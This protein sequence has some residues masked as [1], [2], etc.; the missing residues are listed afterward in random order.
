M[1]MH[2]IENSYLFKG[3]DRELLLPILSRCPAEQVE[4]GQILIAPGEFN[5]K[6]YFLITGHLSIHLEKLDSSAIRLVTPGET[7][8]ELSLI[9]STKTSAWVVGAEHS[10][11]LVI[12]QE[13]L[14]SL[15]NQATTVAKNLLRLISGWIVSGNRQAVSN[16]RHIEELEGIARV[17]GLTGVYNRRTF[18]ES[19]QRLLNRCVVSGRP[20]GLILLDADHFKKYNDCHGH[21]A[22]DQA[23]VALANV[24]TRT[25]RPGD[26]AARYGG[27]E[28]AVILPETTLGDAIKVAERL[29]QAVQQQPILTSDGKPLPGITVS[30]G[31]GCLRDGAD[32]ESIL[33]EADDCLYKAKRQGRNQVT[34]V[35]P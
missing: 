12:D 2:A 18:D 20:F 27:E 26:L 10:S 22:G 14:W 3:V 24:I 32:G 34:F 9:G 23:L 31:I 25:I 4:A 29:R 1:L 8:G 6:V 15:I 13:T 5:D 33:K 35:K 19:F 28:F 21:Q 30:L 11:V 7:V 16:S 17:D